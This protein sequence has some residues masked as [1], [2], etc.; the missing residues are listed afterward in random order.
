MTCTIVRKKVEEQNDVNCNCEKEGIDVLTSLFSLTNYE[1]IYFHFSKIKHDLRKRNFSF[2][3]SNK[4]EI[5]QTH[6]LCVLTCLS[7][8]H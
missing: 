3:Y 5:H 1:E 2:R 7:V 8:T 4:T 6:S